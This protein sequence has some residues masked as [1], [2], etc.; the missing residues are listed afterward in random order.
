MVWSV[1]GQMIEACSC[2]MFCP[3][4]F[5]P[6]EP[7][8]GWCSAALIFDVRSG[9]SD[10]LDLAGSKVAMAV[11]FPGDMFDGKGTARLLID[12]GSGE[13]KAALEAIFSGQR[14]SGFA[15]VAGLMA[16]TLPSQEAKIE[17]GAGEEYSI[18]VGSVGELKVKPMKNSAGQPTEVLNAETSLIFGAEREQLAFTNGSR[19]SDPDM[20]QWESGGSGGQQQFNLSG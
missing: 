13:R 19:W 8:Q 14:G 20:R 10:G 12:A 11:D 2:K 16:K 6:A 5:G 3:C 1:S 17:I 7:D 18:R 15:A 4:T 9:Q